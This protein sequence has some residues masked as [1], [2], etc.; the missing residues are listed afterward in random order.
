MPCASLAEKRELAEQAR[1]EEEA[2][3]RE[4]EAQERQASVAKLTFAEIF[5]GSYLDEQKISGKKA[6]SIETETV[7]F[8]KWIKPAIG[9]LPLAAIGK[10]DLDSIRTQMLSNGMA[11][12]SFLY[13]LAIISQ[14]FNLCIGK[15][16]FSGSNP[17]AIYKKARRKQ[18]A[19]DNKKQRFLS[20][21]EAAE[22][23]D[24][25]KARSL[26]LY[27]VCMTS[28]YAGLRASEIFRLRWADVDLSNGF[29]FIKDT[30]AGPSRN[31]PL[32]DKLA[33]MF[34]EIDPGDKTALVFTGKG[35]KL[36]L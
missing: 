31:V 24:T 6:S 10:A 2:A 5:E 18:L 27:Y 17:V 33:A 30:K 4:A 32:H 8:Q 7:L 12:R 25:I 28:L 36:L 22:L 3:I 13:V 26:T 35:G 23:L 14:L 29:L 15:E 20:E 1:L 34:L 19:F 9:N 16:T 21:F 11:I